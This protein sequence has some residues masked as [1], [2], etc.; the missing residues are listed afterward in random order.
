MEDWRLLINQD[1]LRGRDL[2]RVFFPEF[3]TK[4]YE[5][6]NSFYKMIKREALDFVKKY[7]RGESYLNGELVGHFWHAHCEFCTKKIMVDSECECYCTEDFSS[8][9]CSECYEEFRDKFLWRIH[10]I[11]ELI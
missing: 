3:W 8:W 5:Q 6:K 2:Y 4:S 11:Q 1:D 10:D 9:V 7:K